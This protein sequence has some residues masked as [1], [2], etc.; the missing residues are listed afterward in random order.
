VPRRVTIVGIDGSGKSALLQRVR[1]RAASL[2]QRLVA[3]NCPRFHDTPN[4]PLAQLSSQLKAFSDVADELGSFELK[5]AALYLRMTLYGPVERFL[6]DTLAP[7]LLVSER[8]PLVDT[9]VYLPLYRRRVAAPLVASSVERLLRERLDARSSGAYRAVRAW[10]ELENVRLG[11]DTDFWALGVE[12]VEAFGDSPERVVA[13]F[14]VRYR[15][16]LPDV[17]VLL[18][19]DVDEAARRSRG[20]AGHRVELHEEERALA[21]LRDTYD[22]VLGQLPGLRPAI[23]VHRIANVGRSIDDTMEELLA[24]VGVSGGAHR[25]E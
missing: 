1:E 24:V 15:T 6:L 17:V 18:E 13:D 21:V 25:E 23:D 11:R 10:H 9:L 22:V 16:T 8:H 7:T 2:P 4:A 5:L 20:R 14:G 19:T 12:V 3:F